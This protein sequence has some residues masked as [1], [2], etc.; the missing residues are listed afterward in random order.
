LSSGLDLNGGV[1]VGATSPSISIGLP[2]SGSVDSGNVYGDVSGYLDT[3]LKPGQIVTVPVSAKAL[4]GRDGATRVLGEHVNVD[5]CGG[6]AYVRVYAV[7]QT[8]TPLN[9]DTFTIYGPIISF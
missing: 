7:A 5:A 6:A 2:L 9:D 1:E 8:S 4:T 3:T